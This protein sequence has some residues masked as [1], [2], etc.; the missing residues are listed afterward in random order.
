MPQ[1]V[2]KATRTNFLATNNYKRKKQS[3][4]ISMPK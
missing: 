1:N 2:T 4:V 3:E